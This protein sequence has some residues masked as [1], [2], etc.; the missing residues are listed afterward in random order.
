MNILKT[1]ITEMVFS[2]NVILHYMWF[3]S[4][5]VEVAFVPFIYVK[6]NISS[7]FEVGPNEPL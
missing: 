7:S 6:M 1:L 5:L 2:R 4:C 3:Y